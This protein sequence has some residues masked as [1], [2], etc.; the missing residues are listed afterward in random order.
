LL[1][2]F[3]GGGWVLGDLDSHDDLARALAAGSG[4][5]GVTTDGRYAAGDW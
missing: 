4:Q 3:H 2:F 1:V 5:A